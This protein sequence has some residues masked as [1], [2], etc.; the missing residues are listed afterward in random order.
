MKYVIFPFII[1]IIISCSNSGQELNNYSLD[2][3]NLTKNQ[4]PEEIEI[5]GE[6]VIAKSWIDINGENLLILSSQGPFEEIVYEYEFTGDER[7]A[8][9]FG[10]QYIKI[11]SKYEKLWDVYDS[12]RHC[13]FDLSV[14]F[15]PNSTAITDLD[16]NGITETT[17]IYKLTCASDVT[18]SR[19]KLLMHQNDSKMG[20]RGYMINQYVSKT[21]KKEFEPDLSKI[22]YKPDKNGFSMEI[23]GRY[24]NDDD[25]NEMPESFLEFSKSKWLDFIDEDKLIK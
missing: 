17:I 22:K 5:K 15:I 8:E 21:N 4:I 24:E 12:E 20:L 3:K 2:L 13:P 23:F 11:N 16:K 6:I 19:M 9:L 14:E 18:P 10:V 7:Y 25:F 1:L